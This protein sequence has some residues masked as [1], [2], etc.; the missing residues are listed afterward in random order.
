M[1][2]CKEAAVGPSEYSG[3]RV[4]SP[5]VDSTAWHKSLCWLSDRCTDLDHCHRC[6]TAGL[7]RAKWALT[8]TKAHLLSGVHTLR[9]RT[10]CLLYPGPRIAIGQV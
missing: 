10:L 6:V 2:G 3:C 4:R 1:P 9:D 7:V 8:T 5:L